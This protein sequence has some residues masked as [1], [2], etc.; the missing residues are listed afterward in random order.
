MLENPRYEWVL[1][2]FAPGDHTFL[3]PLFKNIY[4][5]YTYMKLSYH[6]TQTDKY[7]LAKLYDEAWRVRVGVD[8]GP[9]S[10]NFNP[11]FGYRYA[12]TTFMSMIRDAH[13][14]DERK[15]ER[16]VN[17]AEYERNAARFS[18]ITHGY[19]VAEEQAK[20]ELIEL[21]LE[22]EHEGDVERN[23]RLLEPGKFQ[24]TFPDINESMHR[25][26]ITEFTE[27][28]RRGDQVLNSHA[29]IYDKLH[30][31]YLILIWSDNRPRTP[32]GVIKGY[33]LWQHRLIGPSGK[34]GIGAVNIARSELDKEILRAYCGEFEDQPSPAKQS[35][36]KPDIG[37]IKR[38]LG[39]DESCGDDLDGN[40]F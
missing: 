31:F 36:R 37:K 13:Y 1:D 7:T 10:L 39:V 5:M 2:S 32:E 35:P 21:S 22:T 17:R 4:W 12:A 24:Y 14:A 25:P 3:C 11:A 6:G 33:A 8:S 20:F 30:G 18:V 28:K 19:D 9:F 34:F 29:R 15:R 38:A 16:L 40:I 26:V 27:T 23:D